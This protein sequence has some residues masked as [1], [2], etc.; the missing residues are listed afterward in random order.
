M[1]HRTIL[2]SV[3]ALLAGCASS[4]ENI[5]PQYVSHLQF[6]GYSCQQIAAEAERVSNRAAQVAGVQD[7]K[8][9]NDAAATAVAVI[10]FWPAAFLISGDGPTAAELSRL[11]G[12]YE[13]LEKAAIEKKC[14]I[15]FQRGPAP[16]PVAVREQRR[17]RTRQMATGSTP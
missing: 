2:F 5:A 3:C 8:A 12:E 7:K 10:L 11:R 4:S 1:I 9:S 6:Q 16:E 14:G 13:A 17:E 15:Q